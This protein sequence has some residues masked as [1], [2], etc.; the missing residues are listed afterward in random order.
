MDGTCTGEHGVGQGKMKYLAEH[1]AAGAR[2]HAR[3]QAGARSAGHHEHP[4]RF[5]GRCSRPRRASLSGCKVNVAGD[6]DAR[7]LPFPSVELDGVSIGGDAFKA[8][9]RSQSLRIELALGSLMRGEIR[10]VEMRLVKPE[11]DVGLDR[12]GRIDWPRSRLRARDAVHRPPDG[13]GRPRHA[14][15]RPHRRRTRAGTIVVQR[16]TALADRT[17]PRPRR[18]RRRR[19]GLW[20][21]RQRQPARRGR[22]PRAADARN[23]RAAADRSRRR[24]G[25]VRWR[26]SPRFDGT[27]RLSRPASSVLADGR[28]VAHEPWRLTGKVQA[29]RD[30]RALRGHRVP[31]RPG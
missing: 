16:R 25:R 29:G 30:W 17:G 23:R 5:T 7:I 24:T 18:I 13:R 6:I 2:R 9:L 20:L 4:A 19:R 31:I 27:L 8:R 3:D 10:A 12:E 26:V 28:A 14:R 15:G 1:G 22:Q 21:Q 11:F